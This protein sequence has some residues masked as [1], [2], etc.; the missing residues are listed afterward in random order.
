MRTRLDEWLVDTIG[1]GGVVPGSLTLLVVA[2]LVGIQMAVRASR[3]HSIAPE[4]L[5]SNLMWLIAF[6]LLGGR[7]VYWAEHSPWLD[8]PTLFAFWEGGLSLYGSFAGVAVGVFAVSAF[9]RR[10]WRAT[11]ECCVPA[12]AVGLFVGRVGC[13]LN[14]CDFGV[15]TAVPWGV[16]YPIASAAYRLQMENG[17]VTSGAPLSLSVHPTQLYE[18]LFGLMLLGVL[19]MPAWRRLAPGSRFFGWVAAYSLCRFAVEGL[20]A[21]T[22]PLVLDALTIGQ[23]W[24]VAFF[25]IAVTA[26]WRLHLERGARTAHVHA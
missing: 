2:M 6:G 17:L 9:G 12:L 13:F 24:S 25:L 20:R 1:V 18:A 21:H 26:L 22:S 19:V 16:R 4:L 14:G 23:C 15:P 3:R 10:D 11:S 8:L 5:A 7:F